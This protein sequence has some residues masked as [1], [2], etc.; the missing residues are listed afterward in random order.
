MRVTC[1]CTCADSQAAA[2]CISN[3][4]KKHPVPQYFLTLQQHTKQKITHV[5][6]F[7]CLHSLTLETKIKT[8]NSISLH[9]TTFTKQPS[10]YP[11]S[12]PPPPLLRFPPPNP[13]P[14]QPVSIPI[15]KQVNTYSSQRPLKTTDACRDARTVYVSLP[16]SLCR[17]LSR[18]PLPSFLHLLSQNSESKTGTKIA[19]RLE[20]LQQIETHFF[21]GV[22]IDDQNKN[23]SYLTAK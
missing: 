5:C 8:I 12:P 6:S 17:S 15:G 2:K 21:R 22:F 18:S 19:D 4:I 10:N 9:R 13:L 23:S 16:S 20:F 14:I 1:T 3:S 7:T 11:D